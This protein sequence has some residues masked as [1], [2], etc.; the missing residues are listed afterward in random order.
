[1]PGDTELVVVVRVNVEKVVV[2]MNDEVVVDEGAIEA[3]SKLPIL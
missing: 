1:M 3:G 2:E